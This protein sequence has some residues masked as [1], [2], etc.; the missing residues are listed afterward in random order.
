VGSLIFFPE[1]S[2]GSE[3]DEVTVVNVPAI[4]N[5]YFIQKNLTEK[6]IFNPF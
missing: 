5:I 2:I 4:V 1:Y 6:K 3:S